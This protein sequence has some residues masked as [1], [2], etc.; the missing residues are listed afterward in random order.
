MKEG[1]RHPLPSQFGAWPGALPLVVPPSA[2]PC[3]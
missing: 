1:E 3:L 2:L